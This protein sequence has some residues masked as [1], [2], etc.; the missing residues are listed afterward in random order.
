MELSSMD[1]QKIPDNPVIHIF[2]KQS[3]A[4][5][6]DWIQ[7]WVLFCQLFRNHGAQL[8][9]VTKVGFEVDISRI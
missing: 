5:N 6:D 3:G 9:F 8:I 1:N 4:Y 7:T 2:A